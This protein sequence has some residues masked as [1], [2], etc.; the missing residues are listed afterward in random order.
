MDNK[1]LNQSYSHFIANEYFFIQIVVLFNKTFIFAM[2]YYNT[3][4][5]LIICNMTRK[6]KRNL[7][8]AIERY[9]IASKNY[10]VRPS[11][12]RFKELQDSQKKLDVLI[13][14]EATILGISE[15]FADLRDYWDTLEV[16]KK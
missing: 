12:K 8:K 6:E 5:I 3:L 7:A 15:V 4:I 16:G 13:A 9:V 11:S 10:A 1:Y 2:C 14:L